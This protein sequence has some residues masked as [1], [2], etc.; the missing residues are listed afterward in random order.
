MAKSKLSAKSKKVTTSKKTTP[1]SSSSSSSALLA[2]KKEYSTLQSKLSEQKKIL[3]DLKKKRPSNGK[4]FASQLSEEANTF[5]KLQLKLSRLESE[6]E[7]Q[8]KDLIQNARKREMQAKES[9][10]ELGPKLAKLEAQYAA[11]QLE[12][13]SVGATYDIE[14]SLLCRS[15]ACMDEGTAALLDALAAAQE[16]SNDDMCVRVLERRSQ[17]LETSVREIEADVH[18]ATGRLEASRR[19]ND[20]RKSAREG[21]KGGGHRRTASTQMGE[22]TADMTSLR[23]RRKKAASASTK[24]KLYIKLSLYFI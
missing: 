1:S 14:K 21:T 19:I 23:E 5:E 18:R 8:K 17:R 7:Q 12:L 24:G 3:N 6:A 2:A 4:T 9:L 10:K 13:A 15:I 11:Q 16:D 20:K 22:L